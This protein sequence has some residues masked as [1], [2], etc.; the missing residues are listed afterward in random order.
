MVLNGEIVITMKIAQYKGYIIEV[1]FEYP[2]HLHD[3]H[4]DLPYLSQTMKIKKFH[5]LVCN[6]YNRKKYELHIKALKQAL[7]HGLTL[8]VPRVIELN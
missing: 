7:N 5:N 4:S 3:S 1:N 2:K 8:K 6:L